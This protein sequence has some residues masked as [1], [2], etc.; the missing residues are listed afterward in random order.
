M[1]ETPPPFASPAVF[2]RVGIARVDITPAPDFPLRNWGAATY[3]VAAGVHRPL[4]ATALTLQ[5]TTEGEPLV[6]LSLD[7]GWW[8]SSQDEWYLRGA[9][10]QQFNLR[11]DC[12]LLHL[13]H[14]HSGPSLWRGDPKGENGAR[15]AAYLDFLREALRACIQQALQM[16]ESATLDWQYGRC[17]L[18]QNRD[19]PDPAGLRYLC[20]YHPAGHADDTLLVGRVTGQDGA[21]RATLVNYA[22]H[23]TT[24]AYENRL[25]SPDFV[26][27]MREVVESQTGHAPCLFLQGASGELAPRETY[28][29]DTEIV[30]AHGRQLGYAVL[31]TLAGMLPPQT[32]LAFA[33]TVESGAPLALW[34]RTN[35]SPASGCAAS[36]LPVELPLKPLPTLAE[37]DAQIADATDPAQE[38]RLLRKRLVREGVGEKQTA[39]MPVWLWR[40]GE[41][42]W[43]AHPNEA[44]SALQTV[45]RRA[46]PQYV[47]VVMNVTNGHFGYL[48]PADLYAKDIYPVW[49][50]PFAA[51]GLEKLIAAC[52]KAIRLL[53]TSEARL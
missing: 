13:T 32:R 17:T 29:T 6:L 49:Q 50:T 15:V 38:T 37:L 11:A 36:C 51:G 18:A 22:C 42:L 40:T 27:A 7:L 19:L 47:V 33:G 12:L 8:L 45:L 48:P 52:E 2:G 44:Y 53:A 3:D 10:L 34:K 9:L 39:L 28:T 35:A 31:S 4:T 21:I 14:T 26:G 41:A 16:A 46:F 30:D 25:L 1:P 23:P 43:V 24:L 20:G 5:A